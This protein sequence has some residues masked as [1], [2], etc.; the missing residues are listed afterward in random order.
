MHAGWFFTRAIATSNGRHFLV[1]VVRKAS[2]SRARCPLVC[3]KCRATLHLQVFEGLMKMYKAEVLGKLPIMQHFLFGSLLSFTSSAAPPTEEVWS[4]WLWRAPGL[5]MVAL[6]YYCSAPHG[7]RSFASI[8]WLRIQRKSG[9]A[10]SDPRPGYGDVQRKHPGWVEWRS[11]QA[12]QCFCARQEL[13][14]ERKAE[15]FGAGCCSNVPSAAA[16][17]AMKDNPGAAACASHPHQHAHGHSH[18]PAH[19]I[20]FD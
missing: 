14:A 13:E 1:M 17:R 6:R 4:L 3:A 11:L 16:A 7:Q 19:L 5:S 2:M 18:A 12:N 8:C 9:G 10:L 15:I 20:P